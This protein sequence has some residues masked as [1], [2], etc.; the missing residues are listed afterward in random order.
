TLH[1]TPYTLHPTPY[2]LHP[3][4]YT[5][6]RSPDPSTSPTPK[7]LGGVGCGVYDLGPQTQ[8]PIRP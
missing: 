3:T 2:T 4:P 6:Y 7:T 8:T 1:P 5:K